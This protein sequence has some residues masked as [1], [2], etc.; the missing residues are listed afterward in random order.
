MTPMSH[1]HSDNEDRFDRWATYVFFYVA[2]PVV[3]AFIV[4]G[5]LWHKG[6]ID[7]MIWVIQQWT[8]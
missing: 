5:V 8:I 6:L 1:Q 4:V 7:A 2:L 3:V